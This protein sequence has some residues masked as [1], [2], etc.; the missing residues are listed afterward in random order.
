MRLGLNFLCCLT[1]REF[2]DVRSVEATARSSDRF[3][4]LE[5]F[6]AERQG[7]LEICEVSLT[8][9]LLPF[10]CEINVDIMG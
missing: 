8:G 6:E 5:C 1:F 3:S 10:S 7:E 4:S 9:L 2:D